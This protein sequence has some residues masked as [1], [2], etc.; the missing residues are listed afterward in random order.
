MDLRPSRPRRVTI[1][2]LNVVFWLMIVAL[3]L[4]VVWVGFAMDGCYIRWQAG[5]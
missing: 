1:A 3:A 5:R 2:V 4:G